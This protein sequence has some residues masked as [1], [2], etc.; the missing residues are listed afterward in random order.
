MK[1]NTISKSYGVGEVYNVRCFSSNRKE[2]VSFGAGGHVCRLNLLEGNVAMH[3]KKW[4][5]FL[6]HNQQFL[7]RNLPKKI[8][9]Q[10]FEALA[11]WKYISALFMTVKM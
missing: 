11:K 1:V 7:F 5:D 6:T 4:A 8:I 3:V 9:G 2:G 10:L